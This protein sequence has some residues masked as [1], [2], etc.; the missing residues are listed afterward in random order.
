MCSDYPHSP[1]KHAIKHAVVNCTVFS[2]SLGGPI[3]QDF[4]QPRQFILLKNILRYKYFLANNYSTKEQ[5]GMGWFRA[6]VI[7]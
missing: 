4:V 2:V 3:V 1:L 5:S 6:G 7:C